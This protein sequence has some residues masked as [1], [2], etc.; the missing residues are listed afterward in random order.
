M[1]KNKVSYFTDLAIILLVSLVFLSGLIFSGSWPQSHEGVRY[2]C[3]IDQF[4][5]AF[6]S[7]ILYPRW[8]PNYY[9][10]YGYPIF[11]F[12]QPG[13][14]FFSLP[15]AYLF[16][17][18]VTAGY[19]S[20]ISMFFLGGAGVYFLIRQIT[21]GRI[22]PLF[23]SLMFL[24]T[25]YIYVNIYVRGDL[26]ELLAMF[27]TPWTFYFLIRLKNR[28][29]KHISIA[30]SVLMLS[31]VMAALV[32]SHPFTSMFFYPLFCVI[33]FFLGLEME[34]ENAARF[35]IAGGIS[36]V[37]AVIFSSPY[38]MTA[39]Q[40]KDYVEYHNA[41]AGALSAENNVVYFQQLFSRF[42]GF[43]DSEPGTANDGMS[44][45]LG[46]P[47]CIAAIL[48]LWLNRENK[49]YL[50]IF[51]L[52]VLCVLMMTPLTSF[53][54]GNIQMLSF[55][56]YPWR[57]LSVIAL[58]QVI[59]I[60]GL[61]KLKEL[62]PGRQTLYYVLA[63]ILLFTFFWNS[64]QFKF[65]KLD[66]DVR[67]SI[68]RHREVRLEKML[69]YESANEFLPK[70][71][72]EKLLIKPRSTGPMLEVSNPACRI[73]EYPDSNPHHMRYR[74][75]NMEPQTILINQLYFPGWKII[76]K[77]KVFDDTYLLK[78]ICKDGRIQIEIPAGENM[79]FE[80]FYDG[81]PGWYIRNVVIFSILI[82]FLLII[83]LEHRKYSRISVQQ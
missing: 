80:A 31:F 4:K 11:I 7:G 35:L 45:Q 20:S 54:W 23:C 39:F 41:V 32:Y 38:W 68:E 70:T 69:V 24:L 50:S 46:L 26:G 81:P 53:L 66:F 1:D 29:L 22:V 27:I 28:I 57:L 55:V 61:W 67:R 58:L 79:Y 71:A 56:Q 83:A 37:F 17:D 19:A 78:N 12:Y 2:L 21:T 76:L 18:I 25:P 43:G 51:I 77:D 65:I 16:P 48:G 42:W 52:Y 72:S 36:I 8:F 13:Y 33:M 64:N 6:G 74:I 62:Y 75:A 9:G 63:F 14:F 3:L 73:E 59:C 60:S 47:H 82:I 44:F 34:R 40:M 15:F 30:P 49:L 5:D 10:G